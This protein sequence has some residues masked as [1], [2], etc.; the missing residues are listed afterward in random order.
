MKNKKSNEHQVLKV[1]KDYNA[2]KSGLELFEKYGVRYLGP[3]DGHAEAIAFVDGE[4]FD[5]AIEHDLFF[6][7]L[8][9]VVGDRRIIDAADARD[10]RTARTFGEIARERRALPERAQACALHD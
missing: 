8:R 6:I 5:L 7:G 9:H 1:L 10:L 3:I 4:E 2:G